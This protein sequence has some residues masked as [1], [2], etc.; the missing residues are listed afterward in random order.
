VKALALA[1]TAEVVGR[2]ETTDEVTEVMTDG[3]GELKVGTTE[4]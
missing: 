1:L 3:N 4:L 2:S